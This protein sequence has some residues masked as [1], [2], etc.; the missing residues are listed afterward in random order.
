MPS[1]LLQERTEK[2]EQQRTNSSV[3]SR[4][5]RAS[6][7]RK[8]IIR[9]SLS[10]SPSSLL[11]L[12]FREIIYLQFTTIHIITWFFFVQIV[13]HPCTQPLFMFSEPTSF[14]G[15]LN[16]QSN[17]LF[18]RRERRDKFYV[19]SVCCHISLW[20]FGIVIYV[21]YC[22]YRYSQDL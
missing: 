12:Q 16:L 9:L 11:S 21:S 1:M 2:Q 8:R 3:K 4:L 20:Q 13:S 10:A 7:H 15:S 22:H 18:H 17:T 6:Q 19:T 5:T 14:S